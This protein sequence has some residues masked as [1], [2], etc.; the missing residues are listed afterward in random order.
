MEQANRV[1]KSL[2]G[3]PSKPTSGLL[4]WAPLVGNGRGVSGEPGKDNF[5][6]DDLPRYHKFK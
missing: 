4:P 6:S 2:A 3:A 1:G 5:S